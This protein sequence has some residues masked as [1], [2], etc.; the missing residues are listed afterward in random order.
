MIHRHGT[1]IDKSQ[2]IAYKALQIEFCMRRRAAGEVFGT[3]GV[4]AIVSVRAR[5]HWGSLQP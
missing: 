1:A 2:V 5:V 3:S 4:C